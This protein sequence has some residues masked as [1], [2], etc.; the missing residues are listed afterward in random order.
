MLCNYWSASWCLPG[1]SNLKVF[2]YAD[3]CILGVHVP[4]AYLPWGR[5]LSTW[6]I[7]KCAQA[8]GISVIGNRDQ[9]EWRSDPRKQNKTC[10]GA[11]SSHM[12]LGTPAIQV[13]LGIML[14]LIE[15]FWSR[16]KR[17]VT[18]G[19][20]FKRAHVWEEVSSRSGAL[21]AAGAGGGIRD[22]SETLH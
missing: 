1:H 13:S 2:V 21:K 7:K 22:E 5:V 6:R 17:L 19:I 3:I 4:R 12:D 8:Y 18:P 14:L 20:Q 10:P 15:Q 9:W 16:V 11:L